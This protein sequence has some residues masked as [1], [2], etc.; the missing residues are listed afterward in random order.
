MKPDCLWALSRAA[1]IGF[2]EWAYKD[3][4]ITREVMEDVGFFDMAT[5]YQF[6]PMM[7]GDMIKLIAKDGWT[8]AGISVDGPYVYLHPIS[9]SKKG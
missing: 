5:D 9:S 3:E 6:R 2:T 8:V 1:A 4:A 7:H